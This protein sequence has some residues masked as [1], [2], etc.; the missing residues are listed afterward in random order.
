MK[1]DPRPERKKAVCLRCGHRPEAHWSV[2]GTV[3]RCDDC[4]CICLSGAEAGKRK[5]G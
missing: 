4:P 3:Y 2:K 5:K 1:Q